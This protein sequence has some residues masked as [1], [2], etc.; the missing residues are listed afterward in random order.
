MVKDNNGRGPLHWAARS[1]SLE[2]VRTLAEN[3]EESLPIEDN[4]GCFPL[5][6]AARCLA[7]VEV[8]RYLA[9]K[10]PQA[11]LAKDKDGYLPL[12]C[13]LCS[14]PVEAR[15][16]HS[17]RAVHR[18]SR[19]ATSSEA[20][21]VEV[22]QCLVDKSPRSL[23][24]RTQNGC[25]PLHWAI[26]RE[27]P[28]EVVQVLPDKNPGALDEKGCDGLLPLHLAKKKRSLEFVQFIVGLC[29]RAQQV[30]SSDGSLPLHARRRKVRRAVGRDLLPR[31]NGTEAG[32]RA[33]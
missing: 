8:V 23:Q 14:T 4:D 15:R 9:D 5:H 17:D 22:V 11:L 13:S 7:S 19:S 30:R 6:H 29:P 12:H 16:I 26:Q 20:N 3:G 25:L 18:H 21:S 2:V 24:Y 32:R 27:Q 28:V 1:R 31:E 10:D 33:P